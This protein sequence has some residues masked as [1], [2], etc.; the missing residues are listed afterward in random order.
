M[1]GNRLNDR[2]WIEQKDTKIA[3]LTIGEVLWSQCQP[4]VP[5]LHSMKVV[6]APLEKMS[7]VV[8]TRTL[9]D[10]A[11]PTSRWCIDVSYCCHCAGCSVRLPKRVV[12]VKGNSFDFFFLIAEQVFRW[13]QLYLYSC[14]SNSLHQYFRWRYFT[15]SFVE[16]FSKSQ[17]LI[18]MYVR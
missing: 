9:E 10:L 1:P 8:A 11:F 12:T 7:H 6:K 18:V 5:L 2:S 15:E 14:L 13:V 4:T 3:P 16:K 17:A